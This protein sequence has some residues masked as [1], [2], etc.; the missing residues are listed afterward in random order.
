VIERFRALFDRAPRR[1]GQV[2][3][4]DSQDWAPGTI[5]VV[6]HP[7]DSL[8]FQSPTLLEDVRTNHPTLTVHLT[9]GD[10]GRSSNYWRSR[11]LGIMAA[12]AVMAQ[13]E[14]RW[15]EVG[16][17]VGA[18]QMML[19]TLDAEPATQVVFMRLPDGG[20]PD[21]EGTR[22]H[23]G[24]SLMNL[25]LG[26]TSTLRSLDEASSYDR[27]TLI[28]ALA[29]LMRT[30]CATKIATLDF[31]VPFGPDDHC[32]HAASARFALEAHRRL[33]EHPHLVGFEGYSTSR[34]PT[35]VNGASLAAKKDAF[36]AYGRF[37]PLVCSSEA[38]CAGTLHERWMEREYI[39]TL[40]D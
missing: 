38:T 23:R 31:T 37:D 8:L 25:W 2:V 18:N 28:D 16:L 21:G 15:S 13:R 35:N 17:A 27:E 11:E 22:R 29:S 24:A 20:W 36:F 5:Y 9:A 40:D 33:T 26:E 19:A 7:D 12:Y 39:V 30:S 32:D 4:L 3:A 1:P 34:R 14:D 10:D 6:A